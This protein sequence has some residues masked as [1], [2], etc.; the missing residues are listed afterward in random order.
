MSKDGYYKERFEHKTRDDGQKVLP[1]KVPVGDN[2]LF[3]VEHDG[4]VT[5]R[6]SFG[7]GDVV[8]MDTIYLDKQE[9]VELAKWIMEVV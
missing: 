7:N 8:I 3:A 1:L 4:R 5:L 2:S 9:A 6:Q